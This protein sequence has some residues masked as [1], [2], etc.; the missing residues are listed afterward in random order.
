M[1]HEID[2]ETLARA[3]SAGYRYLEI[4]ARILDNLNV[5]PVPDGDTGSNMVATERVGIEEAAA[6]PPTTVAGISDILTQSFLKESRGNSGFI[7]SQF[8]LGFF[9]VVRNC[10]TVDLEAFATGF[11]NGAYTARAALL[12]PEEGTMITI[13][14]EMADSL[15]NCGKAGIRSCLSAALRAARKKIEETPLMLPVLARAGVVDAGGL[16]FIFLMEGM[17]RGL[18]GRPAALEDEQRYRFKPREAAEAARA[19]LRHRYCVELTLGLNGGLDGDEITSALQD[20]GNSIALAEVDS[21]LKLHIHTDS[22]E[23]VFSFFSGKGDILRKKVDDM[24]EQV[25]AFAGIAPGRSG[26]T[27]A[28]VLALVPGDGFGRIFADLGAKKTMVFGSRLPSAGEIARSLEGFDGEN[29]IVLPNDGNIIPAARLAAEQSKETVVIVP[30]R[31][32]AQ[33]ISAICAYLDD[34]SLEENAIR[35]NRSLHDG[36]QVTLYEVSR[37]S[38]YGAATLHAGEYFAVSGDE[39]L[40]FGPDLAGVVRE[41]LEKMNI[42]ARGSVTIFYGEGKG[43]LLAGRL[44]ESLRESYG[45]L[46]IRRAYGGQ[47]GALFILAVE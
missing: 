30:T 46:E 27:T 37:D 44:A 24:A 7:L 33:G 15:E 40:S 21:K 14:S 39:V 9:Q 47:T 38:L 35:M 8:F 4:N 26:T 20:I 32:I 5:Y 12:S 41:T 17:R 6:S 2:A 42:T 18:A 34:E 23:A 45:A 43:E 16:G 1:T 10:S 31:N 29:V 25:S 3:F 22:P 11:S 13:M 28:S 19:N 36:V